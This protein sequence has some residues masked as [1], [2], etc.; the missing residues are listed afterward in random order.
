MDLSADQ[1]AVERRRL[2]ARGTGSRACPACLA[3]TGHWPLAWRLTWKIACPFHQLL[4]IDRCPAC[5]T[6]LDGWTGG[7]RIVPDPACC[8]ARQ[9]DGTRCGQDLS[10]AHAVPLDPGSPVLA[11]HTW[12]RDLIHGP[13]PDRDVADA[14]RGVQTLGGWAA[15][16]IP[17]DTLARY[18]GVD[19]SAVSPTAITER[20]GLFPPADTRL[21]A[22]IV[23]WAFTIVFGDPDTARDLAGHL[24]Q[25]RR[26][27]GK[28]L[29]ATALGEDHG[30]VPA[31]VHA[32]LLA[33]ADPHLT[34]IDRLR[35]RTPTGTAQPLQHAEDIAAR[36]CS[37]PAQLW[38]DWAQLLH[39]TGR[40][41][42]PAARAALA[43]ALLLPGNHERNLTGIR[44]LLGQPPT[45]LPPG[46]FAHGPTPAGVLLAALCRLA[47]HLDTHPAPIDY[48]RRRA[49]D[50]REL[51]T[52][53]EWRAACAESGHHPGTRALHE[54]ARRHIYQR[55]AG[56]PAS[57]AESALGIPA[58]YNR[59]DHAAFERDLPQGLRD[60]LDDIAANHL[61]ANGCDGPVTWQPALHLVADLL[62]IQKPA[63]R[64]AREHRTQ[65][66]LDGTTN[67]RIN[68]QF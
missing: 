42:S 17:I 27:Q 8:Q 49:L 66:S 15:S 65:S 40:L 56:N 30:P 41:P 25:A 10:H 5:H 61:T 32:L 26:Q 50:C 64:P 46:Y 16:D 52:V 67:G 12:L 34:P 48:Q 35:H 21:L 51:L 44:S 20:P 47:D 37:I 11:A 28:P 18:S 68:Q 58:R 22:A 54:H 29:S 62:G 24:I 4:L 53:E 63:S 19:L 55:I 60:A 7:L 38:R 33:A 1:R 43:A 6:P 59:A 2:W 13:A 23:A 39:P 3:Q 14:L 45:G 36:A 9:P 57:F 31:R